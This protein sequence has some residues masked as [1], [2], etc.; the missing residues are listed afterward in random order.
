M[1]KLKRFYYYTEIFHLTFI[2]IYISNIINFNAFTLLYCRE[3]DKKS[4]W[5]TI[6]H[7]WIQNLEFKEE[8][9]VVN[10]HNPINR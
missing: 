1:V 7:L 10:S 4:C 6:S 8:K 5:S 9:K 2:Y 3:G